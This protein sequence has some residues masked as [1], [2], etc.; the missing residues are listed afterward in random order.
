[1]RRSRFTESQIVAVLKEAKAWWS[2]FCFQDAVLGATVGEL[3]NYL[4]IGA[5]V[6]LNVQ[7][8]PRLPEAALPQ[9]LAFSQP[10]VEVLD[11]AA[12]IR[13]HREQREESGDITVACV[14]EGENRRV[15][16]R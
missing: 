11:E 16:V 7:R 9:P 10:D 3:P 2:R 1:M 13:L 5:T 4:A 15:Q 14:I 8:A 6:S 12:T